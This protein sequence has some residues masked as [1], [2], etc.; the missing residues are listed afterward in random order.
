MEETALAILNHMVAF[1][2]KNGSRSFI[3]P[4]NSVQK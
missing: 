4:A 3:L 1:M 2:E